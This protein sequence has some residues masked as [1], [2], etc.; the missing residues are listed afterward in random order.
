MLL[1]KIT[2]CNMVFYDTHRSNSV[3]YLMCLKSYKNDI[4]TL[5]R[6]RTFSEVAIENFEDL[7][8]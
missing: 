2:K 1:D 6:L 7:D 4:D 8:S 5:I 3:W